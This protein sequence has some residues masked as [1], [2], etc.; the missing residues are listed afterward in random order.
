VL[1]KA[2]LLILKLRSLRRL[3]QS[4]KDGYV[5]RIARSEQLACH[6]AANPVHVSYLPRLR[7]GLTL[8]VSHR[9]TAVPLRYVGCARIGRICK[10]GGEARGDNFSRY[11]VELC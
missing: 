9:A 1:H 6:A 10:I 4:E 2:S 3:G 7:A 11:L 8:Q 5:V